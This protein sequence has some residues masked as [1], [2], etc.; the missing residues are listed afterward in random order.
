MG[1]RTDGEV[2]FNAVVSFALSCGMITAREE[3]RRGWRVNRGKQWGG[4]LIDMCCAIT[5]VKW[6]K[7]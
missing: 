6:P 1:Q 4:Q 5:K 7:C 2:R 3:G